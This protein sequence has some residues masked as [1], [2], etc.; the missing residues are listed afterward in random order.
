MLI[1]EGDGEEKEVIFSSLS[2]DISLISSLNASIL[3]FYIF[4]QA[5]SPM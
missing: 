3:T 5:K 2:S 1:V 4:Y